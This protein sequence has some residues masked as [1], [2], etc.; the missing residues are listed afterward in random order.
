ML[1]EPSLLILDEPFSGF[2]PINAEL[3]RTELLALRDRG[4]TIILSTHRMET[5]ET[6]CDHIALLNRSKKIL[7]GPVKEIRRQYRTNL[8]EVFYTGNLPGVTCRYYLTGSAP[9]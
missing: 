1:H 9:G 5:V 2:D 7:E 3:I 6:L 4:T 8:Y